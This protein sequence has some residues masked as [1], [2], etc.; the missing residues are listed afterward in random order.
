[1][2]NLNYINDSP[3]D[4]LTPEDG[5]RTPTN[6]DVESNVRLLEA[7]DA[8]YENHPYFIA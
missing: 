6:N 8:R 2:R 4:I 7:M 1:M 3:L 5:A